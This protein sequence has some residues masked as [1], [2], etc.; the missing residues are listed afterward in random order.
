[1]IK[2]VIN[3]IRLIRNGIRTSVRKAR[4]GSDHERWGT[5]SNLSKSWDSRTEQIAKL[6]VARSSVIEFGAGR[7][8]LKQYL[9]NNCTYTPSDLVDRGYGTIVC[10]L[11]NDVLP[12]FQ[13]YDYAVFSGVLEYVN[14]VPRLI[15]HLSSYVDA[16]VASYAVNE[17]NKTKRR[18]QGWVNDYSSDQF[19]KVFQDANFQCEHTEQWQSQIIYRF[20]KCI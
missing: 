17:L 10:D 4:N 16:I 13:P 5:D 20:I 11:N 7:L 3:E 18:T 9:P 2:R 15:S 1:M 19:V 6:I 12:Q 8:V 14:D